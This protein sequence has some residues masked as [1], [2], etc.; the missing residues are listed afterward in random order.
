MVQGEM[1]L[2]RGAWIGIMYKILGRNISD[3]FNSSIFSKIAVEE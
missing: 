2:L 3:R 1:V